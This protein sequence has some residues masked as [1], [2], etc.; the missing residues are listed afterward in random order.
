[1]IPLQ[2][3]LKNQLALRFTKEAIN[4]LKELGDWFIDEEFSYI[5]IY[6]CEGAPYL[7]PRYVPERLSLREITYQTISV[8]SV[9][10]FV[11]KS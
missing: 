6:G 2:L 8:G 11:K 9:S 7:L 10:F 4:T 1:M 5:I 3:I